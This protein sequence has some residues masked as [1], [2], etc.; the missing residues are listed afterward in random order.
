MV[1]MLRGNEYVEE[2]REPTHK[3][4]DGSERI[5][6]IL[7]GLENSMERIEAPHMLYDENE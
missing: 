7:M 1:I 2:G 4:A 3:C 6:E 5:L